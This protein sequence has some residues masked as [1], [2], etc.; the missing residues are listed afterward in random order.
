M[1]KQTLA[2]MLVL[3]TALA[4]V[5]CDGAIPGIEP[6]PS[7]S[8]EAPADA[9]AAIPEPPAEPETDEAGEDEFGSKVSQVWL[10]GVDNVVLPASELNLKFLFLTLF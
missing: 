4:L 5:A 2:I 10:E 6:E 7:E 9:E 1:K 8:E 3:V